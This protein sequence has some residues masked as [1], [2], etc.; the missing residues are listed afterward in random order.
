MRTTEHAQWRTGLPSGAE[1]QDSGRREFPPRLIRQSTT[2][3]ALKSERGVGLGGNFPG[4]NP[5]ICLHLVPTEIKPFVHCQ[6]VSFNSLRWTYFKR[7][8]PLFFSLNLRGNVHT[9]FSSLKYWKLLCFLNTS[10]QQICSHLWIY[11]VSHSNPH[12]NVVTA[13]TKHLLIF[14][15]SS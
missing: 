14:S 2:D 5:M 10:Y 13:W 11:Y 7:K 6:D 12:T 4:I 15:L 9:N 1:R 8:L 3:T